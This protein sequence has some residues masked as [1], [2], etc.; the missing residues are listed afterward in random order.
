MIG[1][2]VPA[3][4]TILG[5]SMYVYAVHEKIEQNNNVKFSL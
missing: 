5:F 4:A 2:A 1:I 3:D